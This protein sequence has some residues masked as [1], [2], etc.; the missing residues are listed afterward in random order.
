MFHC[1]ASRMRTQTQDLEHGKVDLTRR[2]YLL[3]KLYTEYKKT[4]PETSA[5]SVILVKTDCVNALMS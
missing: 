1:V 5:V 2:L 3:E 4:K